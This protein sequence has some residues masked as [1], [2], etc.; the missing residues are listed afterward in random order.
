MKFV[1]KVIILMKFR[2]AVHASRKLKLKNKLK[3]SC[4]NCVGKS[5]DTT[6]YFFWIYPSVSTEMYHNNK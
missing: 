5:L 3:Y 1:K 4:D 6:I 2:S